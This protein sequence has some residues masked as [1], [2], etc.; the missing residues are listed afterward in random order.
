V[1]WQSWGKCDRIF[2]QEAK[3]DAVE[4]AAEHSGVDGQFIATSGFISSQEEFETGPADQQS[5]TL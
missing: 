5:G 3:V 4:R 2:D 1:R